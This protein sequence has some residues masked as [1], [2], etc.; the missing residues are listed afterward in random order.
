MSEYPAR[1]VCISVCGGFFLLTAVFMLAVIYNQP[2]FFLI[3]PFTII[4]IT[5]YIMF[6]KRRNDVEKEEVLLT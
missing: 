4:A 1:T 5:S 2:Y 6:K 3:P